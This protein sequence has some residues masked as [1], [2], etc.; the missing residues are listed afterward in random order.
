M[1]AIHARGNAN[2]A[3]ATTMMI[4]NP[5]TWETTAMDAISRTANAH[6]STT[7]ATSTLPPPPSTAREERAPNAPSLLRVMRKPTAPAMSAHARA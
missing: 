4:D 7:F 3:R 2:D 1:I 6:S 5:L